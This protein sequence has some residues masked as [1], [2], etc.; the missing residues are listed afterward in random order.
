MEKTLQVGGMSIPVPEIL[1]GEDLSI[2]HTTTVDER[3]TLEKWLV[4]VVGRYVSGDGTTLQAA[5]DTAA[6]N[7]IKPVPQY[8]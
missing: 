3:G 4:Y 1:K 6:H 8:A 7:L 5:L 2:I